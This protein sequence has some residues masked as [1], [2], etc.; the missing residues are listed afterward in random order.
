MRKFKSFLERVGQNV[1]RF[2]LRFGWTQAQTSLKAGI[3]ERRFQE[4]EA[5]RANLTLKSLYRIANAFGKK[6]KEIL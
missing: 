5:G 4:I 3:P 6:P 1:K 2:R